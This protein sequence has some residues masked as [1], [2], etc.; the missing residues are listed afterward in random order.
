MLNVAIAELKHLCVC[1]RVLKI[2][3]R[4]YRSAQDDMGCVVRDDRG[5]VVRDDRGYIGRDGR[6]KKRIVFLLSGKLNP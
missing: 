4:P 2:L 3:R 6:N 5:C 1:L